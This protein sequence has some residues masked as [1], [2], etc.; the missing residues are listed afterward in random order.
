VITFEP[1]SLTVVDDEWVP[2]EEPMDGWKSGEPEA[3]R[4]DLAGSADRFLDGAT[5]ILDAPTD[6]PTLWGSGSDVLWAEGEALMI[7]GGSGVGKTTVAAQVVRGRLGLIGDLL[8]LPIEGGARRVLYLA[9]DR[10][11]QAR[12]ALRRAFHDEEREVLAECLL[13]WQGPPLYDMAVQTDLLTQMCR[14]ADA[15]TV[16]IDSLKD[17]AIG[18]SA[19]EVGAGWNRAR[20]KALA[21]GVQV[22]ELH[23]LVKRNAGGGAPESIAD[24]YGSTWLTAGA[25]SVMLLHGQPGDP[26][27]SMRHLKQPL[28]EVGP[29][30]VLHD[31]GTGTSHR[32]ADE[33]DPLALLRVRGQVGIT[34]QELGVILFGERPTPAQ[35]QKSRR[36]LERLVAGD[37]AV[38][39]GGEGRTA[40]VRYF[41]R[42]GA[43][44]PEPVDNYGEPVDNT[45]GDTP[46]Q[47]H[48]Q[49]HARE[50]TVNPSR[51]LGSFTRSPSS[52]V[53]A[54]RS[55]SRAS[56]PQS[57]T[58]PPPLIGGEREA[59]SREATGYNN[60]HATADRLKAVIVEVL[61]EAVAGLGVRHVASLTD[62]PIGDTERALKA[63]RADGLVTTHGGDHGQPVTWTLTQNQEPA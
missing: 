29:W 48:A 45:P 23:H 6:L 21:A 20:Q 49:L 54:S 51:D 40:Q 56:R 39:L 25:G 61:A 13:F 63:M 53:T 55:A 37:L 12:R 34:A 31:H 7:C 42:A 38:Q 5:F 18:L 3:A 1:P 24:I 10:P 15:D 26:V 16:V 28:D 58:L 57:F 33:I 4:Q 2:P 59:G 41:A 11:S 22:L 14:H 35:V 50:A 43:D 47:L 19:D 30:Q 8:G 62:T 36:R 44:L 52:Q 32:Q 60:S 9:M 17:A 27:V 46:K